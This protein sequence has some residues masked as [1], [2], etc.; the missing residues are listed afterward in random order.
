MPLSPSILATSCPPSPAGYLSPRPHVQSPRSLH[1]PSCGSSCWVCCRTRRA[2]RRT[3]SGWT[4]RGGV[5]A[6]GQQGSVE[7]VGRPQEQARHEL[8]DHGQGPEVLLPEGHPRQGG[9]P[10]ARLPVRR[11]PT[12]WVHQGDPVKEE[13]ER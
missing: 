11:H 2:V 5:Q 10:E 13:R 9:R 7:V 8:R 4:D 12:C 6:G 1:L 3:S